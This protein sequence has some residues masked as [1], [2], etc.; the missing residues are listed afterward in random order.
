MGYGHL[1][2]ADNVAGLGRGRLVRVDQPPFTSLV[3]VSVWKSS[4]DLYHVVSRTVETRLRFLF[5]VLERIEDIPEDSKRASMDYSMLVRLCVRMGVGRGLWRLADPSNNGHDGSACAPRLHTFFVPALAC[6]YNR[7]PG[8]NYQLLCDA[9]FHRVWAPIRPNDGDVTY[10]VPTAAGADRLMSYG[11]AHE[12]IVVTGFPLP[13]ANTGGKDLAVLQSDLR[14]RLERLSPRSDS[15]LRLVFA[16]SGAGCYLILLKTLIRELLPDLRSGKLTLT[17]AA[18]DN[19]KVKAEIESHLAALNA[20]PADGV[21]I[22]YSP[23]R[24]RIVRPL[25]PSAARERPADHQTRRTG[26]LCR[27]RHPAGFAAAGRQARVQEPRLP[28][29]E[30]RCARS[31]RR[32]VRRRVA[33]GPARQRRLAP[34]RRI[35]LRP[36]AE[37]WRV[38]D[39]RH[40]QTVIFRPPASPACAVT[41][42]SAA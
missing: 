27:A 9:D 24:P 20:G 28:H 14:A 35:R 1:R 16:L 26:F 37:A 19:R 30:L 32:R 2:A 7:L 34:C 33:P 11:V 13:V 22:L 39:Q 3:D 31:S 38:H 8:K 12:R 40:R 18:G 15:P 17:L 10:L 23:E 41:P 6:V 5:R 29:G 21:T 25:Q 4:Q 42:L 36:L